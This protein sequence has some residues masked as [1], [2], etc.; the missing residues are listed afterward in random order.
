MTLGRKQDRSNGITVRHDDSVQS[1][2]GGVSGWERENWHGMV[3]QSNFLGWV[4]DLGNALLHIRI[5]TI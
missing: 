5:F 1:S 3:Q 4:L 2:F